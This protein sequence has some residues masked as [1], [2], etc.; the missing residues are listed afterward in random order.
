VTFELGDLESAVREGD[1]A[2]REGRI[3]E[4]LSNYR[5]ILASAPGRRARP[6]ATVAIR[7]RVVIAELLV[8]DDVD[9]DELVQKLRND[10]DRT[11]F[12][13]GE[14]AQRQWIRDLREQSEDQLIEIRHLRVAKTQF[15]P[16]AMLT[17]C[18]HGC[19]SIVR[20][21]GYPGPHC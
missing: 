6:S 9:A 11:E 18:T 1:E 15:Q 13:V 10:F 17:T 20:N 14:G 2:L 4:A 16:L 21:C 5:Y 19:I 7:H 3:D 12:A 8:N